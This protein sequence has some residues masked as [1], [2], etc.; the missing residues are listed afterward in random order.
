MNVSDVNL[1]ISVDTHGFEKEADRLSPAMGIVEEGVE[2]GPKNFYET[3][4]FDPSEL[5]NMVD[6][7]ISSCNEAEDEAH[8]PQINFFNQQNRMLIRSIKQVDENSRAIS[9]QSDREEA[10]QS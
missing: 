2:K 10:I 6:D 9:Q 1:V 8:L 4:K 7:T 5:L 3:A